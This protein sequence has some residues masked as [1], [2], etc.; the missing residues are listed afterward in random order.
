MIVIAMLL[1]AFV[2]V[3]LL[4]AFALRRWTLDEARTEARLHEPGAH[5]VAYDVP[6]GQDAAVLLAALGRGGYAAVSDMHLGVERVL[7]D[8]PTEH[9]RA[10][11]RGII[12][13]VHSTGFDGAEMQVGHV[14][15]EDER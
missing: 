7:V 4:V 6:A 13:H 11:V 12:E 9:D 15:F 10:Q 2:V 14:S 1:V 5:T 3:G 8:C